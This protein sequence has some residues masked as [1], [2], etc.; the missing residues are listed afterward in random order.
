MTLVMYCLFMAVIAAERLWEMVLSRRHAAWSR[1]RGGVE[2]GRGHFPVMVVLH[3]ALL[4][5]APLEVW[6]ADRPFLPLLGGAMLVVVVA[7]QG[8]RY[9]VIATLGP[10]W[11]TR[12]IIVPG[13]RRVVTGPYRWL[14]HPN[15]VAVVLEGVALPLVHT[16][17]V[18]ALVFTAC[19]LLLL[20]V[21]IRCEDAALS[22][23][24]HA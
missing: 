5:G 9:W 23:L 10:Q 17:W 13:E 8:L 6:Y 15:Y 24:R 11:N 7:T 18:T 12:V 2:Y 14:S 16:A 3:A 21:R 19:N 20:S 1:A 22:E 4:V